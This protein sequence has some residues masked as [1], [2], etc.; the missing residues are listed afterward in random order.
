MLQRLG[1]LEYVAEQLANW[2][3]PLRA[4]LGE[5]VRPALADYGQGPPGAGL[6]DCVLSGE[7]PLGVV[8]LQQAVRCPA[9]DLRGELPAEVDR[10]DQAGVQRYP[11]DVG[12]V[13]DQQDAARLVAVGLPG[14]PDKPGQPLRIGHRQGTPPGPP[15]AWAAGR[16]GATG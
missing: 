15:R 5:L 11:E 13:A 6:Q 2:F 3:G 16:E 10:I 12:G 14:V 1:G 4:H 8:G 9:L 7:V